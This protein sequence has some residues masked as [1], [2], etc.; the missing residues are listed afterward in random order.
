MVKL[1]EHFT[2]EKIF[3]FTIPSIG[4]LL[5]MS[6]YGMIDGFFVSN[7]V[8]TLQFAAINLI[9][10]FVMLLDFVGLLFGTGGSA[11]VAKKLGEGKKVQANQIFSMLIYLSIF[12]GIIFA[13]FGIIFVRDVAEILGATGELL[14]ES[15]IYAKILFIALP[16][17]LLQFE[18]GCFFPTAEK[19]QLGFYITV[20]TGLL[21]IILDAIFILAFGWGLIGAAVATTIVEILGGIVSFIYFARKNTSLL[22]LTKTHLDLPALIQTCTN[23]VSELISSVSMSIVGML[24]NWQLLKYAGS[25]GVA[26]FGILLY[27]NFIFE[28]IFIG[29]SMG[30]E[31]VVAYNY[32][33]KRYTELQ[34]LL[35]KSLLII[36]V[37]GILMFI[38]AEIFAYSLAGIFIENNENILEMTV[39]AFRIYSFVFL[40]AGFAIFTSSFFTALNNGL[41]SAFISV[42]RTLVFE[43]A[44]VLIFPLIWGL[45][46]IWFSMTGADIMAVA[47]AT[48]L[49]KANSKRY[50]YF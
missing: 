13:I 11:L 7:F 46:G 20:L 39:N 17:I 24:Y 41:L 26:A 3:R 4:V 12:L 9:F 34:S 31:A 29:Y 5:F 27:I 28:S 48:I 25:D 10:P 47:V 30:I 23:G 8:G 1:S 14:E 2:Y 19:P 6:L 22:Q 38:C 40:F 45:N 42:M 18:F 37:S 36:G 44:A 33:A 21:N 16:F 35:R 43:V 15:V 49:L 50:K 32:G